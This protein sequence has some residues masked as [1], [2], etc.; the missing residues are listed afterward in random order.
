MECKWQEFQKCPSLKGIVRMSNIYRKELGKEEGTFEES[1]RRTQDRSNT[2]STPSS[3]LKFLK[4]INPVKL[5][6]RRQ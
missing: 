4:K 6:K 1:S 3:G 5:F 2:E